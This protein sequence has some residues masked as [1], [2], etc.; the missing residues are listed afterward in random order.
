MK[1]VDFHPSDTRVQIC[2]LQYPRFMWFSGCLLVWQEM[3]L[4]ACFSGMLHDVKQSTEN[5]LVLL[6]SWRWD[7]YIVPK[8]RWQSTNLR[9]VILRPA[10]T[11]NRE[12]VYRNSR[13][14]HCLLLQ[15]KW[16]WRTVR[17]CLS[18]HVREERRLGRCADKWKSWVLFACPTLQQSGGTIGLKLQKS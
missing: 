14:R 16:T 7:R 4:A 8:R 15:G 13:G 3:Q 5:F 11:W 10:M 2:V 18:F 17:Y 9:R 1:K 6:N 12:K